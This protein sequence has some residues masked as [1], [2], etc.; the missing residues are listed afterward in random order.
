MRVQYREV[1]LSAPKFNLNNLCV[2][3]DRNNF[4]QTGSGEE[5]LNLN[6]KKNG[7]VLIGMW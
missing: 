6:P 1:A 5:I 2:I 3:L 7:L 4:Q